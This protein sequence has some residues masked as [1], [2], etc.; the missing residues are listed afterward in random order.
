LAQLN[1][2]DEWRV[3]D[4]DVLSK[5]RDFRRQQAHSQ[6]S[7]ALE[8]IADVISGSAFSRTLPAEKRSLVSIVGP[9]S[10]DEKWECL[11]PILNRICGQRSSYDE[12]VEAL[13]QE[14]AKEPIVDYLRAITFNYSHYFDFHD[15]VP[16]TIN[17]REGFGDLTWPFIRAALKLVKI[18]SRCF[19]I[20]V[21]GTKERK[22]TGR[23][24]SVV[25]EEQALMADGVAVFED[26]QIYLAEVSTIYDAKLEKEAK[27]KFKLARCMRDS[28]N[29]QIKSISREAIP[30]SG[31]TVF[32]STSFGDETK[33]YA[34]DFAG[35]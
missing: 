20:P 33:F 1:Q 5:F 18:Q 15:E 16:R 22:N 7:L 30:P 8:G 13:R 19:E 17:E 34:M 21:I 9:K 25:T 10:V 12:V 24:L 26:H 4:L 11:S 35:T 14:D 31:L 27:D 2:A 29:S 28:W 32:G 23:D 6:L 3:G